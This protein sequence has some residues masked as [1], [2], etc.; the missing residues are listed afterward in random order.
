MIEN[1]TRSAPLLGALNLYEEE[2][3]RTEERRQFQSG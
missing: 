1:V 3:V 2:S